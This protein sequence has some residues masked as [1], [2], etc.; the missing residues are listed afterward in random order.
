MTLDRIMLGLTVV[1]IFMSGVSLVN[2]KKNKPGNHIELTVKQELVL[3]LVLMG[4]ATCLRIILF[5]KV[6]GGMNQDGAMAAVDAKAL[7][8]YGTDR[9][10]MHMPVHLTAWVYGQMSALLSYS[11][12]PFIK[13]MG[14]TPTAARLPVL[15]ASITGL[16]ALYLFC[17]KMIGKE[18]ALITLLFAVCNPWHFMQSRWAL[19][20]NLFPHMF[21][22]G[23]A[24]LLLGIQKRVL[25]YT[26]MI[27]FALCM[28][29]YGISFYTVPIF[30]L[31][32]YTWLLVRRIIK[33]Y[34]MLGC[35]GLYMLLSWPIY[36]TMYINMVGG[37]TIETPF[38]TIP[39]FAESERSSDILFFANGRKKQ[40][41]KN[42][43][44]LKNVYTNG[45]GLPWNTTPGFGV[46]Y[47][48]FVIFVFVGIAYLGYKLIKTQEA[49]NRA[50]YICL[51]C[52]F[53]VA[54]LSGL[55]TA[56]VNV[57][58][59]NI[60]MY[61]LIILAGLGIY[62]IYQFAGK[63]AILVLVGYVTVS[64]LFL[65]NYFTSHAQTLERSYYKSFLEALDTLEEA[66]ACD[67]YVITPDSACPGA[68]DVSEILTLF[69]LDIDAKYYQ[70]L[71]QNDEGLTYQEQVIYQNPTQEMIDSSV[72]T[73]YVITEEVKNQLDWSGYTVSGYNGYYA[74][75]PK[76]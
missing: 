3:V 48:C 72:R 41:V 18:A 44:A 58:R 50:G 14:L 66:G 28:Y 40:L 27:F 55:I 11:M 2:W 74:A 35:A 16:I 68:K 8:T 70:G 42:L 64:A 60:L 63:L 69:A 6:P 15:I 39:Y 25:L 38:F 12:A 30:L 23:L 32:Y 62:F 13:V 56:E 1:F 24:L 67:K 73:G 10:G 61:A 57:N 51:L 65:H 75:V 31:V 19:D 9:F 37:K 54:N 5:G 45:D 29:S 52:Y 21:M 46:I 20:C 26:S 47:P 59:I 22:I 17:R 34:D 49:E 53:V 7:T 76:E 4:L 33:W 43:M 71:T 36:L